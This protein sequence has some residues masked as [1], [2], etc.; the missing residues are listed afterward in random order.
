[1]PDMTEPFLAKMTIG[2]ELAGVA[3]FVWASCDYNRFI[4]FWMIKPAPYSRPV[5]IAFRLFFLA[6]GVGGV[7]QIAEGIRT[8]KQHPRFYLGALP[9][10]V[11]WTI[12]IIV[13]VNVVERMNRRW[14]SSRSQM[15]RR[16]P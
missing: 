6:C 16:Q 7:W 11:A 10:A 12:A 14:L 13:L 5:T 3:W 9:F 1:M 2:F 4:K 15:Q 8:T